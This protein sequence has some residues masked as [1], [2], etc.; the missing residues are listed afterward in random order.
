MEIIH[1]AYLIDKLQKK[2]NQDKKDQMKIMMM[3]YINKTNPF[4]KNKIQYIKD[5]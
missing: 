5:I 3:R 1:N 2:E 4:Q